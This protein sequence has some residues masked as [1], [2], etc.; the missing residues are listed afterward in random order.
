MAAWYRCVVARTGPAEDG[1]VYIA[2]TDRESRF[3]N[4]WFEALD[5]IKREM[6]ATALTAISANLP[7]D[8]ALESDVEYSRCTRMY[9]TTL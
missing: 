3:S 1:K 4:R 2:L 8:A 6:L 9:I 7:V 5:V